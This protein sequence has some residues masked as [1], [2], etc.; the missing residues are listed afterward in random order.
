VENPAAPVHRLVRQPI[1]I[2]RPTIA[3]LTLLEFGT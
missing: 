1:G 2:S 3:P